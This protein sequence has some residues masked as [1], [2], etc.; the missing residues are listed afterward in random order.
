MIDLK[1]DEHDRQLVIL[2]LATLAYERPGWDQACRNVVDP[3]D[4]T[5]LYD[6]FKSTMSDKIVA[7]AGRT[8]QDTVASICSEHDFVIARE[9]QNET[10]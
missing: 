9:K 3:I 10:R 8:L 2:A 6:D 4:P 5:H 1:L 7:Y